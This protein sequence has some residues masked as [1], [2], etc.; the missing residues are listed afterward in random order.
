MHNTSADSPV[1]QESIVTIYSAG[2]NKITSSYFT[3]P[4]LEFR[5]NLF[6]NYNCNSA[7]LTRISNVIPSVSPGECWNT[8]IFTPPI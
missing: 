7:K 2:S 1:L 5:K 8:P 4:F 6:A 3:S